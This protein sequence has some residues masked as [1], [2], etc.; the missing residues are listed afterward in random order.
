VGHGH[1]QTVGGRE[2]VG[3]RLHGLQTALGLDVPAA[4]ARIVEAPV[5]GPRVGTQFMQIGVQVDEQPWL[6][7]ML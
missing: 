3:R 4:L 7:A 6:P 2:Q 5:V 1:A